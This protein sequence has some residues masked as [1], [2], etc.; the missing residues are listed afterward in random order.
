MLNR[1]D[2]DSGTRRQVAGM[3]DRPKRN[4]NTYCL[5]IRRKLFEQTGKWYSIITVHKTCA[6]SRHLSG[7]D[8]DSMSSLMSSDS[9]FFAYSTCI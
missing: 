7:N 6:G 3:S 9:R 1:F 4:Q 5:A 2:V 8:T